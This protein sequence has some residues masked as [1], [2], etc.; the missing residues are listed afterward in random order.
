MDRA[1]R[2]DISAILATTF[3]GWPDV[4]SIDDDPRLATQPGGVLV[5]LPVEVSETIDE[6]GREGRLRAVIRR[7][8]DQ[9]V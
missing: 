3:D 6:I 8:R 4:T 7:I 1:D 5:P 9:S 2:G